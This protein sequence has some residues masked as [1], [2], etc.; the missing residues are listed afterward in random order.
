MLL[1]S[2]NLWL[3]VIL[4]LNFWLVPLISPNELDTKF[5]DGLMASTLMAA[6]AFQGLSDRRFRKVAITAALIVISAIAAEEIF[7]DIKYIENSVFAV[8]FAA[9]TALY[10]HTMTRSLT[11]VTFDTVLAA[12]CT[13]ILIG[14]FFASIFGLVIEFDP[15]AFAPAESVTG[16]YDMLYFSFATLTTLGA[17]DVFPTSDLS[18]MLM[19][20]EAMVGL[21]YIAILVGAVV[22]SYATKVTKGV[23]P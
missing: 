11:N 9:V 3:F 18:R 6:V 17:A 2:G 15:M 22:G 10:F 19:V 14:M 12:A 7:A 5:T 21:I 20:F 23:D 4:S 16:R 8:C 13:Y 1:K